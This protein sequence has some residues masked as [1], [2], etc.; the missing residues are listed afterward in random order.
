MRAMPPQFT[1]L[2]IVYSTAYS[3]AYQRK[4]QSSASLAFVRRINGWPVNSPNKGSVTRKSFQLMTS[5]WEYVLC[6]T[7][8]Y[9]IVGSWKYKVCISPRG[10]AVSFHFPGYFC[11]PYRMGDGQHLNPRMHDDV[12]K[13]KIFRVTGPS[14]CAGNSPVAGE[15]PAQRPVTRSFD[16]FF[17][18]RLN[19]RLSKQSWGWWSETPPRSLWRQCN[20]ISMEKITPCGWGMECFNGLPVSLCLA[21]ATGDCKMRSHITLT[22]KELHNAKRSHKKYFCYTVL[23]RYDTQFCR[24]GTCLYAHDIQ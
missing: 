16:V 21:S 17:D 13:W 7:M 15:F 2:T 5:S 11:Q 12:I 3:G 20:G 4:H 9:I 6:F 22:I 14:L 10:K 1:S 19:K 18:L 24:Q 8:L 23:I